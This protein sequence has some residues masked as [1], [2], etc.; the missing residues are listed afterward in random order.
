VRLAPKNIKGNLTISK[1]GKV[2]KSKTVSSLNALDIVLPDGVTISPNATGH[3]QGQDGTVTTYILNPE[4]HQA[5]SLT[6]N[7]MPRKKIRKNLRYQTKT[8]GNGKAGDSGV[9]GLDRQ[10]S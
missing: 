5:S 7:L 2:V 10:L 9:F 3:F 4:G 8:P 6:S 1:G